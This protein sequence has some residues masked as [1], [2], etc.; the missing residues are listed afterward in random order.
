MTKK[1]TKWSNPG[2]NYYHEVNLEPKSGRFV[3]SKYND[4]KLAKIN[5]KTPRFTTIKSTPGP[6]NYIEKDGLSDGAKYVLSSYTA[7][8]TRAF[9]HTTRFGAKGLWPQS[10]TPGPGQYKEPS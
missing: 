9:A 5:P 2:P 3:L 4:G 7:K 1:L 10:S 6:S 8:G